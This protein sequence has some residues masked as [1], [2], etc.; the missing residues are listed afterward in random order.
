MVLLSLMPTLCAT[1]SERQSGEEVKLLG[2]KYPKAVKTDEI[3]RSVIITSPSLPLPS[4]DLVHQTV[5]PSERVFNQYF[6]KY[7]YIRTYIH[8]Y[9]HT[10]IQ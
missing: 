9:I 4:L 6:N 2:L 10:Y 5:S 1:P 7:R 8:T 3:A